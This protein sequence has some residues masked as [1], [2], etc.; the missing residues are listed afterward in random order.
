M[1]ELL[2]YWLQHPDAQG[3]VE[4]I[5]EW[6]LLEHRIQQA[7]GEVRGTLAEL[8]ARDLVQ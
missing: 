6:W 2:N 4:A 3:T 5:V 1:R 8:V 7:I